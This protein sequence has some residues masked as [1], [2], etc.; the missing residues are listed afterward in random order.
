MMLLLFCRAL[1]HATPPQERVA[2]P[3]IDAPRQPPLR[4]RC[5]VYA[6]SCRRLFAYVAASAL[7]VTLARACLRYAGDAPMRAK[8]LD[9]FSLITPLLTR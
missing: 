8:M 5:F 7:R 1:R 6:D 9:A 3:L 4:S 2:M